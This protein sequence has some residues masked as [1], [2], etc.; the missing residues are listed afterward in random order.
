M[1]QYQSFIGIDQWT[2]LFTLVNMIIT[3]LVLKKFFFKPVMKMI[4]DRQQEIDTMYEQAGAAKEHS[5][6]M[7]AEY[8]EKL[9]AAQQTGEQIVKEAVAR[10]QTREEEILRQANREADALRAKAASD[11]ALE[12]KKAI[13]DAKDEISGMAMAI[14]EKVVERQLNAADQDRMIARFIDQLG[15]QA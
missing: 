5:Q 10:G 6:A 3:F 1:P 14:A 4:D 9:A 12:K 15:D 2:V 7:E 8:R 13:N 11:I